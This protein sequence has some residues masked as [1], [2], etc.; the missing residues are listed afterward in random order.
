MADDNQIDIYVCRRGINPGVKYCDCG[1]RAVKRCYRKLTGRLDGNTCGKHLCQR[2]ATPSGK[3]TDP[4]LC[5]Q[6]VPPQEA[7]DPT[8]RPRR[9]S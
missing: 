1:Q 5:A 3:G 9:R 2:C 6:H 4:G 8:Q 7:W